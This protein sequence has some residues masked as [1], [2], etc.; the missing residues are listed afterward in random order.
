[1]ST[2]QPFGSIQSTQEYL[3][4]LSET[5][6]EALREAR[7]ELSACKFGKERRRLQAWQM[8]L[9]TATKLSAHIDYS[10]KLMQDLEVLRNLLEKSTEGRG[11]GVRPL[12][13][14]D[15]YVEAV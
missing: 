11:N 12:C 5:I 3:A 8:V 1:M 15:P 14:E 2:H 10:R 7:Q 13:P 9:Y 6:E 4:L